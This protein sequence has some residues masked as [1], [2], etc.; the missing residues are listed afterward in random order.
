MDD[1]REED[2]T[3]SEGARF[4]A[5]VYGRVGLVIKGCFENLLAQCTAVAGPYALPEWVRH[6]LL[7]GVLMLQMGGCSG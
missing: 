3:T 4:A 7:C 2:H 5:I 1:D 6:S